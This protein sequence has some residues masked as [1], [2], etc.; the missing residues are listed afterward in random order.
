MEEFK[1]HVLHKIVEELLVVGGGPLLGPSILISVIV[2]L[3]IESVWKVTDLGD[4]WRWDPFLFLLSDLRVRD[5][6][7]PDHQL[8]ISH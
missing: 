1:H 6:L 4:P 2:V 5:S 8:L 7:P 3:W